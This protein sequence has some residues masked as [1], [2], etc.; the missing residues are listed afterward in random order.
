M[1]LSEHLFWKNA[2][3]KKATIMEDNIHKWSNNADES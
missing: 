2:N 3:S 1:K